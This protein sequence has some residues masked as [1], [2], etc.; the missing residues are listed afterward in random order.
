MTT[1]QVREL[2][3]IREPGEK[4]KAFKVYIA[5]VFMGLTIEQCLE[6]CIYYHCGMDDLV[7]HIAIDRGGC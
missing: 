1:E 5:N 7:D 4:S 2:F 3:R 6:L